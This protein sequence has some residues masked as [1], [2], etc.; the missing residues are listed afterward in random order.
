MANMNQ[1][2]PT[3]R[4]TYKYALH[5]RKLVM[6]DRHQRHLECA[7]LK[8]VQAVAKEAFEGKLTGQI[9]RIARHMA[10]S[11]NAGQKRWH[12]NIQ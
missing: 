8:S 7:R 12:G 9:V 3:L 4:L 1:D 5:E 10:T 11:Y 2:S 6:R